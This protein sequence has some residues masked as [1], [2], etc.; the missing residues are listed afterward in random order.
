MDGCGHGSDDSRSTQ[1]AD[2]PRN[3]TTAQ[4]T[5]VHPRGITHIQSRE[6]E[7]SYS[8]DVILKKR[9]LFV[10]HMC[11][12]QDHEVCCDNNVERKSYQRADN[13]GAV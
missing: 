4:N 11:E 10:S 1:Q 7:T 2:T 9:G 5:A 3:G 13:K 12:H 8:G 6:S